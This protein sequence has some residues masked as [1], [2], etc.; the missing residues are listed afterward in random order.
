V[1]F[2]GWQYNLSLTVW[3]GAG[4]S[5]TASLVVLVNDTEAPVSAFQVLNSAGTPVKGSAIVAGTNLSAK[6]LFN[7][8][9]ASD[10]HNGS[11]VKYYWLVTNSK[12]TTV[13]IGLNTTT[14]KPY[15]S[16]WL[17][18]ATNAYTVNLTVW[19]KN[20]NKGYTTQSLTVSQNTTTSPI[21]AA[22][23]L[24][25]PSTLTDGTSYTF[26]VNITVGGGAKS[27]ATNVS[28]AFYLL[29]PSG[30]GSRNNI[31]GAPASVK[32]YNYV[33]G[34]VNT[35]PFATGLI[36]S[37]AYN[38]TVRAEITWNPGITG[39][40][41]LYAN[42]TAQN[43]FS[44]DY[45]SGPNVKTMAVTINPNP[46]TQ[47]LE[48]VAI[49]VVVVVVIALLILFYRR[50]TGR[51]GTKSGTARSGLE[52]SKRAADDEDDEDEDK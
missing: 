12:N 2:F 28:V 30:G 23:N 43:E 32:F 37:L 33:S 25:G 34:V 19:D 4:H 20:G 38:T 3:D 13:H 50:R 49:A 14:V 40:F 39:S 5:A 44:G 47:L 15:P 8:A 31:G 52:R 27:V 7:G 21:M 22:T 51:A 24:T 42:V 29:S 36:S 1:T 41:T 11:V 10:P 26:W 35:T 9:N 17:A 6:V 16:V 45:A 46:T 48:Y 18:A